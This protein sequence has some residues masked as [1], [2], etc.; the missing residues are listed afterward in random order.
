MRRVDSENIFL[1]VIVFMLPMHR[2]GSKLS[3]PLE[4]PRSEKYTKYGDHGAV[5][6]FCL[7]FAAF[8]AHAK[9]FNALIQLF[10]NYALTRTVF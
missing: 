7:L 8:I 6:Y 9:T 1:R 3:H 10:C 4:S 2:L 5:M